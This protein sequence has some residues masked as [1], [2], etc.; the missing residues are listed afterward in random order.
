MIDWPILSLTTFLPLLG[1]LF[2]LLVPGN[3]EGS[4]KNIRM[5]AL[6]TTS[7]TFL[8]SL[9]IW[10]NFDY[11]N[12]GFQF[13]EHREWL[14]SNISYR[15]GVDGISVLFVILTTFLM[16][17][18]ILASWDSVQKRVKEYMIAFLV[19]ETLMIGVFCA[20]D[21]VVFY[22][23]FEAGLIPMFLIIGVWGGAR[24]VYA[25]YKFFLYTLLG[26]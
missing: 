12:S 16:P 19:L 21:L 22:V 2:I 15:M 7:V 6:V 17:F 25:S 3:D 18:C 10:G 1:V 4:K 24:R 11:A 23:F 5:V 13:V 9:F 20:L 14:G 26:S 8:L